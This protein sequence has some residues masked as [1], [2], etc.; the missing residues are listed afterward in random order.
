M[1]KDTELIFDVFDQELTQAGLSRLVSTIGLFCQIVVIA[2]T[3]MRAREAESLPYN[4]LKTVV[5]DG[6][7]H[8][9]VQGVT[10]KLTKGRL[11]RTSWVTSYLGVRAI[12]LAQAIF[13]FVHHR[14]STADWKNSADGSHL[15]VCRHGIA[16]ISNYDAGHSLALFLIYFRRCKSFFSVALAKRTFASLTP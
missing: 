9:L 13:G 12:N 7:K 16:S 6:I 1:S 8:Y 14:H 2:F 11:K 10:T 4:C 15:L 3:G 5:Q